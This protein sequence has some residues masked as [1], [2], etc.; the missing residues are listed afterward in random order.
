MAKYKLKT[1]CVGNGTKGRDARRRL[2]KEDIGRPLDFRHV[3]HVGWDAN[4]GFEGHGEALED[5]Q[6]K[7][8]LSKVS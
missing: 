8:I 6:L 7:E 1:Y 2:R 4:R 3:S 5:P